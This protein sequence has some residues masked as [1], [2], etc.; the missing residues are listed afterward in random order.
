MVSGASLIIP[1]A[2]SADETIEIFVSELPTISSDE[3]VSALQ[4]E[5]ANPSLYLDFALA[6]KKIGDLDSYRD[7]L[8][9]GVDVPVPHCD[10]SDVAGM[11]VKTSK[12]RIFCALATTK[13]AE[14]AQMSKVRQTGR[15]ERDDKRDETSITHG[16]LPTNSS[17]QLNVS[18]NTTTT[19]S[20]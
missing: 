3:I 11:E 5:K 12:M 14:A 4:N 10:V 13:V 15:G 20:S 1:L 6:Y 17:I 18:T 8:E 7:I 16:L 2:S 9:A 19:T